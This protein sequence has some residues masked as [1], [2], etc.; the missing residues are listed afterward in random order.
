[1]FR[2]GF[3]WDRRFRRKPQFAQPS[4]FGFTRLTFQINDRLR[5]A[6]GAFNP[7]LVLRQSGHGILLCFGGTENADRKKM[8]RQLGRRTKATSPLRA[9]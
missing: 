8:F 7:V 9:G 6:G 5:L 1:M 3:G 4:G 2:N